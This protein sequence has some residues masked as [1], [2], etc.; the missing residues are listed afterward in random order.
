MKSRTA[1]GVYGEILQ[2]RYGAVV[3]GCRAERLAGMRL[4]SASVRPSAGVGVVGVRRHG[5]FLFGP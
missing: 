4:S 2:W 5:V 1:G 3:P